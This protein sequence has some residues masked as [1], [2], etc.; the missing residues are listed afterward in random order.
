MTIQLF[1]SRFTSK[2]WQYNQLICQLEGIIKIGQYVTDLN[3]QKSMYLHEPSRKPPCGPPS[4]QV[5]I[6]QTIQTCM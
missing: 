5:Y 1:L 3:S 2:A 4:E 6:K